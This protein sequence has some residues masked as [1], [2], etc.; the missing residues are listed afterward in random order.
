MAAILRLWRKE[1]VPAYHSMMDNQRVSAYL[2]DGVPYPFPAEQAAKYIDT[3]LAAQPDQQYHRAI[4]VDGVLAGGLVVR[5]RADVYSGTGVIGYVLGEA[6][7]GRGVMT[8]MVAQACAEAFVQ[9]ELRRIEAEVYSHNV[10]S[11]RVLEKVGFALEATRP[12]HVIKRGVV[13]DSHTYGLLLEEQTH[14]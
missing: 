4:E 1:D 13:M 9:L 6:F 10:G 14:E 8:A 12:R 5:R 2:S 11:C 3:A 7:W